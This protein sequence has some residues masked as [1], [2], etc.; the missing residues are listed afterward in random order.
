MTHNYLV[1]NG[2][3]CSAQEEG[4]ELMTDLRPAGFLENSIPQELLDHPK[5]KKIL[6]F[7]KSVPKIL[8]T[9]VD[10]L[11][12]S[13]SIEVF[14]EC[15]DDNP[16]KKYQFSKYLWKTC[17]I[18]SNQHGI[19]RLDIRCDALSRELVFSSSMK[20]VHQLTQRNNRSAVLHRSNKVITDGLEE[21]VIASGEPGENITV[22]VGRNSDGT[23]R[24]KSFPEIYSQGITVETYGDEVTELQDSLEGSHVSLEGMTNLKRF[25]LSAN[26]KKTLPIGMDR[27]HNLHDLAVYDNPIRDQF[28][29]LYIA[30]KLQRLS[31]F[32]C[33][34]KN[35][36]SAISQ[37]KDLEVLELYFNDFHD[38][39]LSLCKF[40]K[41]KRLVIFSC[42]LNNYPVDN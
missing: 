16:S 2:V 25:L 26:G 17:Q 42:N 21:L 36:P 32:N 10:K 9:S 24:I 40:N 1:V 4:G 34:L 13:L 41:L 27:L 38:Q 20:K 7:H 19:I 37:L 18:E 14:D 31:L 29:S 33:G 5:I 12:R 11:G 6:L 3:Q 30:S 39:A 23:K 22:N 28:Q 35:F 8:E 15:S